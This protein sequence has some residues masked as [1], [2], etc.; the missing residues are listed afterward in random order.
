MHNR[1]VA[2]LGLSG[3]LWAGAGVV[4]AHAQQDQPSA[5]AA[6]QPG[7][8]PPN[9]APGVP[10]AP[11]TA[12][13]AAPAP[14]GPPVNEAP[15]AQP[16]PAQ[17]K[18]AQLP[19]PNSPP[20]VR[21]IQLAF[22]TQG[23]V[24]VIEPQTY[25]Y[26]I[27][28]QPSRSSD[29]VWVPYDEQT[30][31]EDFKRLWG[32]KFLDNLWIDVKDEPYE[33]GVIGKR[34][35]YNMEERQRVKIVDYTGSKAVDSTKIDEKLKEQNVTIRLDSF[36]DPGLIRQVE[37]IV[38]DLLAEKGF[39]Y[40]TVTHEIKPMPGGPKLVHI[41]FVM[42][43]GP[44]V[45]IRKVDFEGNTKI[46]DGT[47]KGELKN[48]K[49]Q[50]IF[51]FITGRGTYQEAKFE[52]DAELLQEFYRNKGYINARV[53]QPQLKV[54]GDSSDGK[55]RYV[56]LKIP[57]QEG[58][59]YKVG[60]FT[61]EGNK[62]AKAEGL[63]PLFKLDEGDFYSN[64]KIRKGLDQARELYGTG[65][66][67]EF[68]GYPDLKPR[69]MP[70]DPNDP[71]AKPPEGPTKT[72]DG[73][74]IVDVVMRLQE[75]EQYFVNRITFIGN[76]TTRDNVIRREI[77]LLENGVFNTEALKFSLKRINQLGYFK[78]IE[79][80]AENPK[81]EKTPG[82]KNKVD[83]TLKFE[84][85]NRN[86]LT[87][88]AGV[89]QFEG[90]FGQ[91][92]F[93]TSNFMGRG[94]SATF[95]ILAGRRAQNY[96]VAFTEP[97]LF[98]RP[99]TAGIDLFKRELRYIFA[100]TQASAGGNIV[101]GFPVGNF[102]RSFIN[103][104]LE[105][106]SVKDVNPFYLLPEVINRNPFLQDALLVGQGGKRTI[107]QI[108]PSIVHNTIDNP[109]FPTQGR[110]YT[111]TVDLAGIGGNT[112]FIKPRVEGVWM[113]KHTNRTSLGIRGQFEYIKPYGSTKT[114]PIFEKLFLG[115]EYSVRGYD[116][117]SIGPRD[118]GTPQQPGTFIVIGGDKSALFNAE[119]LITIAGPV[120]L[121]L[122]YDAGQVRD[123]GQS[124]A[125][126]EGKTSTGAEIRFFM[127][128]LNVPFRLIFAANPQRDG[129]YDNN[130]RPAKQFTFK[131]AV[132]STF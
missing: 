79:A 90:F 118:V 31:L 17:Q 12:E 119:Y 36:I 120:R 20:L 122:F 58:E 127:P 84:E 104:S 34:I 83:V 40:A 54:L 39:Q 41:T 100:Y 55:T 86:Q 85:Q 53:G 3:L 24:S 63:R 59:R 14:A 37:G 44:K 76:T 52:E 10:Q 47:L 132:G 7:E 109:I 57:V 68:T 107:S 46:S 1:Y 78:P 67:W 101:F 30:V 108:T 27:Q 80:S 70:P 88:G 126:K 61:F 22:P 97:F 6:S 129:V 38:R 105:Q 112:N 11:G 113:F 93:Q 42:N 65:G 48:N 91:L 62:V 75:G 16:A 131:F 102:T 69:D 28:T 71:D 72:K 19:P 26:Y 51:S 33:N 124:F 95:S 66:Y 74:P 116:I 82:E 98:D 117:R 45:K 32:T 5:P 128:V 81:V 111:A 56:E 125:W 29:G 25:L 9:L 103:Y 15:P 115:G 73:Y 96:Q 94:E 87:F 77:R 50:W 60:N 21:Y 18:P 64:K 106:V 110:R 35:V 23:D 114:L 130:L 4:A 121:V 8:Q 13:P 123:T 99:I 2:V 92:A 89:S 43:E 49:E